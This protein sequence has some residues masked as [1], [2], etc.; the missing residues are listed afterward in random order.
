MNITVTTPPLPAFLHR[1]SY[2]GV[3]QRAA[4]STRRAICAW[5]AALP[6][7]WFDN[8]A[9]FPDGTSRHGGARS[10]MRPLSQAWETDEA[11]EDGFSVSFRRNRD[12]GS[13]WGLRLHQEGGSIRPTSARALT[14]P[15][16]A[17]A[18]GLR[19]AE[20]ARRRPLFRVGNMLA[21][22]DK[23]GKL[24]AAYAL[25]RSVFV[26]PLKSRRG[27]DALPTAEQ[28]GTWARDAISAA[29]SP[30]S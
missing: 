5:Y 10:F 16:T 7:D 18:R 22:R 11:T 1:E 26:P 20:F 9:P 28:L 14:I 4:V 17:E 30:Q 25:K 23:R 15:M 12:G 3:M 2:A 24:H 8:P 27:H 6:E 19:A 13:P 21:F 29:L